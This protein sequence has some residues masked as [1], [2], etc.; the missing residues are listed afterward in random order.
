MFNLS[1]LAVGRYRYNSPWTQVTILGFVTFCSVGMYSAISGLGAGGTQ[2]PQLSDIAHGAL[3]GCFAVSGFFAG[4]VNNILGP[5]LTLSL[6]STGY[7]L[8]IGALWAFQLH[9]TRWFLILA[10]AFLGVSA[11]LFW[12]AQGAIMMAYPLEKDRGRAFSLA[13]SIFQLG[14][15]VGAAIAVGI[16]ANS[17]LPTVSTAVYLVFMIIMLTAILTSWLILPPHLVVRKDGTIVQV[18]TLPS[19]REEFHAFV[20]QLHDWRLIALFPM[21]FSSNYFYAYQGALTQFLFTGRARALASLLTGVGSILGSLLFGFVTDQVQFTRQSTT[22]QGHPLP[23]DWTHAPSYAPLLLLCAY[24]LA[25]SAYQ[26]LAYY[27]MST[28]TSD[29]HKL[30]RMAGYYKGVQSAGNAI[31]YGMDAVKTPFLT[32]FIVSWCLLLVSMPLSFWVIW[33]VR[34]E[35]DQGVGVV[36][37]TDDVDIGAAGTPTGKDQAVVSDGA[38]PVDA[39]GKDKK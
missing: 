25:E 4:S 15:L 29:A 17:T 35:A 8:Y 37:A 30:A 11:A 22:L 38:A 2:D 36:V 26:G 27:I 6:G 34:K 23:W 33:K 1:E 13:W 32:E 28:L 5:R 14:V 19:P 10:G 3:Y 31:S 7:S 12:A 16:Q 20:Q 18:E 9:G 21:F 39:A 24:Y